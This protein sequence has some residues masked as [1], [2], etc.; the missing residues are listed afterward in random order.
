MIYSNYL[1]RRFHISPP[2]E[3]TQYT[4]TD[5]Y[6]EDIKYKLV[7]NNK[8]NADMVQKK[9]YEKVMEICRSSNFGQILF[10][11]NGQAEIIMQ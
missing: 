5:I 2:G 9:G 8:L 7:E 10:F 1:D 11:A 6:D 3:T 4:I